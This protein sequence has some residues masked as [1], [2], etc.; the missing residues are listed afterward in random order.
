MNNLS[1]RKRPAKA[2]TMQRVT[3][4]QEWLAD[5]RLPWLHGSF[6]IESPN[7]KFKRTMKK[8]AL[9]IA[10]ALCMS[11]IAQSKFRT[12]ALDTVSQVVNTGYTSL[13]NLNIAYPATTIV[14]VKFYDSKIAPVLSS[15]HP[16]ITLQLGTDATLSYKLQSYSNV[17]FSNGLWIRCASG[18]T[19]TARIG[20]Q[21]AT[22]PIV[23]IIY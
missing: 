21:P 3:C 10:M 14:Y 16:V 1:K 9:I 2:S 5:V 15:A 6:L 12:T 8:T 22:K 19:D 17:T 23:E 18:I 20:V 13:K 7:Y 11:S 4:F